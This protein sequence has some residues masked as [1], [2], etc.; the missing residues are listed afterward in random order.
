MPPWLQVVLGGCCV[1]ATTGCALLAFTTLPAQL[2]RQI[3]VLRAEVQEMAVSLEAIGQRWVAYKAEMEGL[4]EAIEDTL[5]RVE[6]KRKSAAASASRAN[7]GP[8]GRNTDE[9][10]T[11]Q[12][13]R[14]AIQR[15]ARGMGFDV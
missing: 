6:K 4:A 12:E 5:G 14:M 15:H 13:H 9:P 11:P 10:M 2:R 7:R 1:L 8:D 3:S